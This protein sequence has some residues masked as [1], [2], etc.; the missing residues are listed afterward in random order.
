MSGRCPF[1]TPFHF[2]KTEFSLMVLR[3]RSTT[4]STR[5]CPHTKAWRRWCRYHWSQG[6]KQANRE[7]PSA[8]RNLQGQAVLVLSRMLMR[9]G[10]AMR[11]G[12]GHK[13]EQQRVVTGSVVVRMQNKSSL[14]SR[15]FMTRLLMA[16]VHRWCP[17]DALNLACHVSPQFLFRTWDF[18]DFFFFFS[19]CKCVLF[20]LLLVSASILQD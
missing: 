2:P 5:V 14:F 4:C 19:E 20:L 10:Y 6:E 15:L 1:I 13:A 7:G 8:R 16:V 9:V 17:R 12:T 3:S 11:R 18:M